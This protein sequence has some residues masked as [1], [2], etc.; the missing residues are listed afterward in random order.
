MPALTPIVVTALL[1]SL[2]EPAFDRSG[3]PTTDGV[4]K[5]APQGPARTE[6]KPSTSSPLPSTT[7][8]STAPTSPRPTATSRP[9]PPPG[10][11]TPTTPS[12][13]EGPQLTAVSSSAVRASRDPA[14]LAE[15]LQ[16]EVLDYIR[17]HRLYGF[18]DEADPG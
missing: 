2:A 7:R 6:V 15:A 5:P 4:I 17:A 1:T 9:L 18:A 10:Q 11:L 8:P 12:D 16:P 13:G 3:Q 14:F